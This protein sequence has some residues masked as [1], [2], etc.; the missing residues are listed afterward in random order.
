M[1][2]PLIGRH[3]ASSTCP[4]EATPLKRDGEPRKCSGGWYLA[5]AYN[6]YSPALALIEVHPPSS[7]R[8]AVRR[9]S[10]E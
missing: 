3:Y 10:A 2:A 1:I 8:S 6:T 9:P 4:V 7:A 5:L